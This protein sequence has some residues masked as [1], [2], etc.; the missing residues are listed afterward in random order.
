M[1]TFTVLGDTVIK[2]LLLDLAIGEIEYF[3][4]ELEDSLIAYSCRNERQYQPNAGIVNR[5]DGQRILFRPF[6]SPETVGAKIIVHPAPVAA[7]AGIESS[8]EPKTQ[9]PLHGSMV[10][11][12]KF[13]HPTGLLNAEEVTG[14][15]TSLSAMLPFVNRLRTRNIV[16]FGAGKQA[17]WHTRLALALRG[18]EITSI[19]IVNRSEVRAR[20]LIELV[21]EENKLRWHSTCMFDLL[22]TSGD[23]EGSHERLQSCLAGADVIFC[24]VASQEP[25][26]SLESLAL[27]KRQGMFPLITAVGSWQSDMIE[28]HPAILQ[29]ITRSNPSRAILVDDAEAALTHSGEIV[30]SGLT[31]AEMLEIGHILRRKRNFELDSDQAAWLAEGLVVYKSIGVSMTDLVAGNSILALAQKNGLGV[32]VSGF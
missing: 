27:G 26:F 6:T 23:E 21:K 19:T 11:C 5:P 30:Q 18:A 32:Q 9:Q 14:Y 1:A 7:T 4:H 29:H 13:G 31:M 15:R 3:L 10:L 24:T 16:V 20:D 17:L 28:V 8:S 22:L 25:L 2:G 12:D